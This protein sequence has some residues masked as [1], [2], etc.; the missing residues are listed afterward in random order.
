MSSF[1]ITV[2]I[3]VI[4]VIIMDITSQVFIKEKCNESVIELLS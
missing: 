4:V 2:V 3:T 1:I